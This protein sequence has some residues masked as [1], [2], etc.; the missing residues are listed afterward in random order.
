MGWD[1]Q[2]FSKFRMLV[3]GGVGSE[4]VDA[5]PRRHVTMTKGFWIG[6]YKIPTELFCMY[7]NE[8]KDA[9][10]AV[11]LNEKASIEVVDGL[12]VPK[13]GRERCAVNCVEW[14]GAVQFCEWLSKKTG[15]K[16]RLPTEAEWEFTASGSEDRIHPWGNESRQP[17]KPEREN[18]GAAK[19]TWEPVDG[20]FNDTTPDGVVGMGFGR[21]GEW[22]FDYYGVSYLPNDVVDPKGPTEDQL[23]VKPIS[24]L[25]APAVGKHHVLRGVTPVNVRRSS[26]AM[27]KSEALHGFRIVMEQAKM[28]PTNGP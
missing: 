4:I 15:R 28:Q 6:K 20:E 9:A 14:D 10:K 2:R 23:P 25:L 17:K 27:P 13:P 21:I 11:N 16:F 26:G 18:S 1:I 12:F 5:A 24:R 7:L 19:A 8:T 22:C 3:G